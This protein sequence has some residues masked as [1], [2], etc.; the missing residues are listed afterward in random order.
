MS[1]YNKSP[2]NRT[3]SATPNLHPMSLS[4]VAVKP[5]AYLGLDKFAKKHQVK[6]MA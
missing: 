3:V 6:A 2:N 4:V 1:S 5:D